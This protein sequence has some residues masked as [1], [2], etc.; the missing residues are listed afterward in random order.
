MELQIKKEYGDKALF[1]PQQEITPE[2]LQQVAELKAKQNSKK[3]KSQLFTEEQQRT[4]PYCHVFSFDIKDDVYFAKYGCCYRCYVK[5]IEDRE[6][7]W[8]AGWRPNK[9][10]QDNEDH[11]RTIEANCEGRNKRKQK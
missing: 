2:Y 5:Y 9:E 10:S 1:V 7:R 11:K 6:E 4:C 8:S 3:Q